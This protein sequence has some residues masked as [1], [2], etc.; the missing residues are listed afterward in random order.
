MKPKS[1]LWAL[2]LTL[3]VAGA[4][5][6][7]KAGNPGQKAKAAEAA[8]AEKPDMDEEAVQ[9]LKAVGDWLEKANQFSVKVDVETDEVYAG[10]TKVQKSYTMEMRVQKPTGFR[11][12]VKGASGLRDYA[13]NGKEF[14]LYYKN[15]NIL[16]SVPVS[17]TNEDAIA[18][19]A[20]KLD[21]VIPLADI[22]LGSKAYSISEMRS[23]IYVGKAEIGG[24]ECHHILA[25]MDDVDLQ[26]WIDAGQ[27]SAIRKYLVNY[28]NLPG[29]PQY[30]ATFQRW[31]TKTP[32]D[33]GS[34][35]TNA[36]QDA[37]KAAFRE[38]G[39]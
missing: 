3:A 39:K 32:V 23:V 16:A 6:E 25:L 20:E 26:L 27:E 38:K 30:S 17:G 13:F 19:A 24:S 37:V 10:E 28:K 5:A 7:A 21:I 14:A 15:R 29:K 31:E 12:M 8:Q 22:I 4:T 1:W 33:G 36:P 2:L 9:A 34:L 11:V 18:F 35:K